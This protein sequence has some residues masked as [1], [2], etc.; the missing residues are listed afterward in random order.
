MKT[1]NIQILFSL[2]KF[3]SLLR[4]LDTN[5]PLNLSLTAQAI[6]ALKM[7]TDINGLIT[8]DLSDA[9]DRGRMWLENHFRVS[10]IFSFLFFYENFFFSVLK[11]HLN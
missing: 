1:S 9:I 8:D 3:Q 6:I 4:S 11:I 5:L 2:F 7:N 10:E